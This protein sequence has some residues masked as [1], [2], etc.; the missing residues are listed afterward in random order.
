MDGRHWNRHHMQVRL[1]AGE[2]SRNITERHEHLAFASAVNS[3]V[4]AA[5]FFT[6][7]EYI[8]SPTIR[9]AVDSSRQRR[10]NV[11][12]DAGPLSW[13]SL[14][15]EK[16]VDSGVSGAATGGMLR[17]MMAGRGTVAPAALTAGMACIILQAAYNEVRVQRIKYVGKISRPPKSNP[18]P[19]EAP[20]K[21]PLSSRIL[22]F[23]GLKVITDEELL[24]RLK[25]EREGHLKKIQELEREIEEDIKRN[26][27]K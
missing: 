1:F 7:R 4:T 27:E 2:E 24:T 6:I 26:T 3:A 17:G 21:Q 18:V 11:E 19:T 13:S 25:R 9:V 23:F 10:P 20:S 22:G 15:K 14:R 12:G 8:V 5:T 16:L